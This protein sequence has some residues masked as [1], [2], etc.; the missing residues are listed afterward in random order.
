MALGEGEL[1]LVRRPCFFTRVLRSRVI[2]HSRAFP[3]SLAGLEPDAGPV[4]IPLMD[5]GNHRR[6][7]QV[8]WACVEDAATTAGAEGETG[9]KFVQWT[10]DEAVPPNT[11]V[12]NNYGAK[13]NEVSAPAAFSRCAAGLAL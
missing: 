12:C 3:P 10:I 9:E 11:Q 13:S 6:G 7:A 8:T 2:S 1:F 4:L 5:S